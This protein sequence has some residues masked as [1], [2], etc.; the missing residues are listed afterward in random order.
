MGGSAFTSRS[1][2][3]PLHTPRMPRAVYE[4]VKA[5]CHRILRDHYICVASPIDGPAKSD[6]GD[7][8]ILVAWP[9]RDG[10]NQDQN[11]IQAIAQL[12]GATDVITR[13]SDCEC[14]LAIPW[15]EELNDHDSTGQQKPSEQRHIQVDV[16]ICQ[17][18]QALEW[19]LLKHAHGDIW[20]I[21]GSVIRPYGLTI[22]E[23]AL[24]IRIP[25]L[26]YL[27][28]RKSRVFLTCN[29]SEV[30][31]FLGL[32]IHNTW[33][34]PFA[35]LRDMYEYVA[36]CPMF[37]A[38]PDIKK[39]D[40]L[41]N[42]QPRTASLDVQTLKGDERRRLKSRP[43]FNRWM[44]DFVPECRRQGHYLQKRTSRYEVTNA[45]LSR[46][47]VS[48]EY[49][50]RRKEALLKSQED[51]IFKDLIKG[52]IPHPATV[53]LPHVG[54]SDSD[55]CLFRACQVKALKKVIL[56]GDETYGVLQPHVGLKNADGLFDLDRVVEF[57]ARHKQEVGE[58]AL[59]M[60]Y[61]RCEE[62]I[63]AK[64]ALKV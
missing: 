1:D 29:P 32:P 60:H 15:P 33:E 54:S 25:E 28:K 23:K 57:I 56:E 44:N 35:S 21:L 53:P 45:A 14:N 64:A 39:A 12:L 13:G 6:F 50:S 49:H 37:W 63:A 51:V 36:Q 8:D 9:R 46:F 2:G 27:N 58:N 31:C 18:L 10:D 55:A 52:M 48:N 61:K 4:Q 3:R 47:H 43:A 7:V 59:L 20:S 16:H 30:L 22:D 5:Q 17:T 26:E 62:A 24:W 40:G 11:Q 38:G 41:N 19:M 42:E 34:A